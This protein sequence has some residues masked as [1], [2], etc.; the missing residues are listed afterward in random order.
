MIGEFINTIVAA[1]SGR[2][3]PL[4]DFW[5]EP[6]PIDIENFTEREAL[7]LSPVQDSLSALANPIGTL[8][9]HIY[10]R[11]GDG[12][13][14]RVDNHPLSRILSKRAN[15]RNTA[16]EFRQFMQ[17]DLGWEKNA[18]AEI[19]PG[20]GG[21]IDQ[22]KP[23][24]WK[25]VVD[26]GLNA[27]ARQFYRVRDRRGNI[28]TLRD[29]EVFHL[30]AG[31]FN[32]DCTCGE[33]VYKTGRAALGLALA[34]HKYGRAFF[35]NSGKSGGILKLKA[36]FKTP[37]DRDK[38]LAAW[39]RA[40]TG[41]N[42]HSDA[43][44]END[45]D[46]VN[47]EVK[48]NEAQFRESK[49]DAARQVARLWSMPPHKI[50][51][52]ERATFTNI[53]HQRLEFVQDVLLPWLIIWEQSIARDLLLDDDRFFAEFDVAGLLRGDLKS[54]FEAYAMGR[55]WG[56]LTVNEIRRKENLDPVEGGDVL[57]TPLNMTGD[58]SGAGGA[59]GAGDKNNDA[60]A[61]VLSVLRESVET[62][63]AA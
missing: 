60:R 21:A 63:E 16:C 27:G 23:I 29:D 42:A 53:E 7:E 40:R 3:H 43:V 52:L 47:S 30:R 57:L 8:P 9:L 44:L 15:D 58:P 48:N 41:N 12:G 18:L 39:R 37:E 2:P 51:D 10:R 36:P 50:G 22:L 20:P 45:G 13:R 4:D 14:R 33:P 26:T 11:D 19:I 17:R 38:F 35:A 25:D 55:Q 61:E 24:A 62:K 31:P 46:Y 32:T 6:V 49:I 34:I 59:P 5:Y 56:W 1:V 28:R 54:R